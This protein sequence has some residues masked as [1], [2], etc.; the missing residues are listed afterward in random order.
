MYP[1]NCFTQQMFSPEITHYLSAAKATACS[2]HII[3]VHSYDVLLWCCNK[4]H[5][6]TNPQLVGLQVAE[7]RSMQASKLLHPTHCGPAYCGVVSTQSLLQYN[8]KEIIKCTVIPHRVKAC[9]LNLCSASCGSARCG[10]AS[11]ILGFRM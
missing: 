3:T 9:K 6:L 5:V 1:E 8:G 4:F 10:H 11:L 2:L 7:F